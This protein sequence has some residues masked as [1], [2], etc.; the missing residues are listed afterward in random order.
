[1]HGYSACDTECRP[2]TCLSTRG[3]RVIWLNPPPPRGIP[4]TDPTPKKFPP[5]QNE[6]KNREAKM[7]GPLQGH[8]LCFCPHTPAPPPPPRHVGRP[9]STALVPPPQPSLAPAAPA[10]TWISG[11]AHVGP[12]RCR[13]ALCVFQYVVGDSCAGVRRSCRRL[14]AAT[15]GSSRNVQRARISTTH[16]DARETSTTSE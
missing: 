3:E 11:R 13:P 5:G 15:H 10:C 14:R 1:M 4:H 8:K 6:I 9:L 12:P 16:H 2:G 7:R